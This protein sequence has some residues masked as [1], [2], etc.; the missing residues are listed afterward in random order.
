LSEGFVVN[1]AISKGDKDFV[2]NWVIKMFEQDEV[3]LL[4]IVDD[5]T[6]VYD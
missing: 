3:V 2:K 1:A 6:F 4:E 5:K